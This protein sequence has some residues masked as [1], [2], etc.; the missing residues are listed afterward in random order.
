MR[1]RRAEVDDAEAIVDA[2]IASW[3]A[4]YHGLVPQRVLDDLDPAPRYARLRERLAD[5]GW[6]RAG[7]LVVQDGGG[8][9][10]GFAAL[11]ADP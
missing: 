3:R 8:T 9:V 6:P 1:V 10:V 5:Q 7:M 4:A 11:P 2:H